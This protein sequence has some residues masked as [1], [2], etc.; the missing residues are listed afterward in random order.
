MN[1]NELI[2]NIFKKYKISRVIHLAAKSHVDRSITD[3]FSFAHTNVMGTLNLLQVAKESWQGNYINKL[4]YHISTDKV[5]E[6]LSQDGFFCE[7]SKY[8]LHYPYAASK[9]SSNHF[10]RS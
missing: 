6:S 10:V 3:P 7:N 8:D 1:H 2:K 4:F 9:A 5:Y